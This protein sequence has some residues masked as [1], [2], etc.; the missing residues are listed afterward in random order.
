[1]EDGLTLDLV[2]EVLYVL[3]MHVEGLTLTLYAELKGECLPTLTLLSNNPHNLQL[4]VTA[5]YVQT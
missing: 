1:M 4:S 2:Y 5:S 3:R